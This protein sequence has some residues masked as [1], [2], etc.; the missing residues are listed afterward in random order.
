MPCFVGHP[1]SL[2]EIWLD[3]FFLAS[4]GPVYTEN[5]P[6]STKVWGSLIL[7]LKA[8]WGLRIRLEE[9]WTKQSIF[10]LFKYH[11]LQNMFWWKKSQG[12]PSTLT[13]CI[14][15]T[16]HSVHYAFFSK[17]LV[18]YPLNTDP[19][20]F[21]KQQVPTLIL[22]LQARPTSPKEGKGLVNC[23]YKLCPSALYT[24]PRGSH[25]YVACKS[26]CNRDHVFWPA[27]SVLERL[28]ISFWGSLLLDS[29]VSKV[30]LQPHILHYWLS[31]VWRSP[32][33]FNQSPKRALTTW[34]NFDPGH[35]HFYTGHVSDYLLSGL[36][37]YSNT[38]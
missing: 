29:Q 11:V 31:A 35:K 17:F 36:W 34:F 7:K 13:Y 24:Q 8:K 4:Y 1:S 15:S 18:P 9:S 19:T 38:K 3:R 21:Y 2:M 26:A 30:K 10:E 16:L 5:I 6:F 33:S 32:W 20:R 37:D 12:W 14:T 28:I 25:L 27:K 22:V 23:V